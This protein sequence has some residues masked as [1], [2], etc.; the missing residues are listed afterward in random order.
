MVLGVDVVSDELADT[1]LGPE[2]T[3][4][5][6]PSVGGG[7]ADFKAE[8]DEKVPVWQAKTVVKTPSVDSTRNK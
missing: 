1:I 4:E 7:D 2:K 8:D 3:K 5:D 6:K